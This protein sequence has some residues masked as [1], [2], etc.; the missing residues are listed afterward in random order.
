M[1]NSTSSSSEG[2]GF[3]G[4]L[5]IA[6]I[7]LKL[8]HYINVSWWWVLLPMYGGVLVTVLLLI[9]AGIFLYANHKKEN[10]KRHDRMEKFRKNHYS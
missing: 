1:S 10:N 5:T 3:F 4:L 6:L 8:T 2:I 7:V 9:I